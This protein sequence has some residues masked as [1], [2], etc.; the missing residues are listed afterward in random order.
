MPRPGDY[1]GGVS[2]AGVDK[3]QSRFYFGD[4]YKANLYVPKHPELFRAP[5]WKEWLHPDFLRAYTAY[6][7]AKKLPRGAQREQAIHDAWASCLTL[8]CQGGGPGVFSLECFTES[9]CILLLEEV[10]HAQKTCPEKLTRPNGMNR[11][12]MVLNQLGLEPAITELQQVYIRPLQT[13]LFGIEGADPDDHHCFIVRYK[14]DEDVGLDMHHDNSDVTL[15]ICLGRQ[16]T[17]AG[18]TF[19]GIYGNKDHRVMKHVYEHRIGRGVI[20]LGRQRHGADDLQSG[21]RLNFILWNT[22]SAW[23]SSETY[24]K[25]QRRALNGEDRPDVVCLSYTHDSDY[26]K[27]KPAL[28][29]PEALKRGVMLDRVQSNPKR[30]QLCQH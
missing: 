16:F 12:G 3:E 15:N 23:R 2:G 18:L 26:I 8:E 4:L 20:H 27:Y 28:S 19:C 29:D 24:F 11:Y 30:R 7:Q 21:E 13:F 1:G 9:F 22:S 17:G 5:R 25:V 6:C 10:D 14:K